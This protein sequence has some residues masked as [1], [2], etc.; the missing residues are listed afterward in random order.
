MRRELEKRNTLERPNKLEALQLEGVKAPSKD[1]T[2]PTNP[3]RIFTRFNFVKIAQLHGDRDEA[4]RL[5]EEIVRKDP[6]DDEARAML[7]E[8]KGNEASAHGDYKEVLRR[9][10]LVLKRDPESTRI[11]GYVDQV[12]A[13]IGEQSAPKK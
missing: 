8:E 13:L 2:V 4:I 5:L 7:D 3:S 9:Y 10:E 12:K 1:L 11:R 6:E